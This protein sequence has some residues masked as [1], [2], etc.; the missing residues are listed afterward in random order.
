MLGSE[1]AEF[2]GC[3]VRVDFRIHPRRV[4][5]FIIRNSCLHFSRIANAYTQRSGITNPAER[6]NSDNRL[7]G[8]PFVAQPLLPIVRIYALFV[9]LFG[10]LKKRGAARGS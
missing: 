9:F 10:E 5:G 1:V 8:W 7:L 3:W 4:S 2:G 6:I